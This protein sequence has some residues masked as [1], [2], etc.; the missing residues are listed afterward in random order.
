M[1]TLSRH[2][3]AV[4]LFVKTAECFKSTLFLSCCGIKHG[5]ILIYGEKK[6]TLRLGVHVKSGG[7]VRQLVFSW[8]Q[9][10]FSEARELIDNSF[11]A[12]CCKRLAVTQALKYC[13]RDFW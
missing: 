12:V 1:G 3:Q 2:G 9:L 5:A 11:P 8:K 10:S 13:H 4:G 7:M 6:Q